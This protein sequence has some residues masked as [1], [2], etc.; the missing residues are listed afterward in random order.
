MVIL[1][2]V[3]LLGITFYLEKAKDGKSGEKPEGKIQG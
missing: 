3:Q 2:K 1:P